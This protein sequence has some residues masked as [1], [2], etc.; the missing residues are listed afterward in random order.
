MC[1]YT[2]PENCL[3][4][5]Y[6]Y[7]S[8]SKAESVSLEFVSKAISISSRISSLDDVK[9]LHNRP[10]WLLDPFAIYLQDIL[11]TACFITCRKS[12][13]LV[14]TASYY[15]Y[16][17]KIYPLLILGRFTRQKQWCWP[18]NCERE[19]FGCLGLQRQ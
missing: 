17:Y 13:F 3:I 15:L 5:M 1:N 4:C 10:S 14:S 16:R 11:L 9:N 19:C 18:P 12:R 8:Q 2:T 7:Y 6:G